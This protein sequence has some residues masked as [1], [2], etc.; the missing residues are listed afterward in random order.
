MENLL[1]THLP[2]DGLAR[3]RPHFEHVTL[4]RG[5]HAIVPDEPIRHFYFPLNCLLSL[6]TTTRDGRSGESG[7]IGREG[8]SGVP[9]LLDA[10]T[11]P[12]PTI[13]QVPGEALRVRA[14]VVKDAYEGDRGVRRYFNRYVHTV[15]V[16][17][18][19]SAACNRHHNVEQRLCRWLLMAG[20]G[21]GSSE[22]A[23]THEYLALML[24]VRRA[25]VTD[26]AIKLKGAGLITYRRGNIRIVD[27]VGLEEESCEC[28]ARTKEEYERL[29]AA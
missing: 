29:F 28:Y 5:H 1:L 17:G 22:V 2:G 27:R 15:I 14:D 9:V 10:D 6:Q 24:G 3:L 18:A 12:M 11:T 4:R 8:V 13:C 20:D 26:V 16:T 21:V 7:A 19:Y 23:L 25:G